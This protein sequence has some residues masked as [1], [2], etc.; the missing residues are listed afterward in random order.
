MNF[1]A[2]RDYLLS[3]PEAIEDYPFGPDVAVMKVKGKMFATLATED[4]EGRMNLK[5]DPH[6]ALMLRDMFVAVKPGYHM[7]KK[8]WNTIHL[9]G[10]IPAGEVQRM[11]DN[12]YALVV[13][14]LNKTI[15][16]ELLLKFGAAQLGLEVV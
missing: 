2:T 11:I 10:S 3:K 16:T 14:S 6:E 7:N 9:D 13:G 1:V 12:S 8:H 15:K 4:G 5:C